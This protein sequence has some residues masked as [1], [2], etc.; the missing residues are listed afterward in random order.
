MLCLHRRVRRAVALHHRDRFDA[1]A[2]GRLDALL[3]DHVRCLHD[4]LQTGVAEPVHCDA[5]RR[6]RQPR[7]QRGDARD[8]VSR[9]AMRLAAAE[10][11]LLDLGF[12]ELRHPGKHVGDG[13][14]REIIGPRLIEG[15]P[16][17][18]RER[19]AA[20]GDD[21]GF[22]HGRIIRDR[23]AGGRNTKITNTRRNFVC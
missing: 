11:D 6:D 12:I 9:R 17:G 2:D 5:G 8:V 15:P 16:D 13:M 20:A 4:G 18:L 22:A 19:R 21:D 7:P 10:H 23:R 1:A 14:S 3:H